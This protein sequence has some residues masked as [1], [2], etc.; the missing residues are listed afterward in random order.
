MTTSAQTAISN[1]Q[2]LK[3]AQAF[4]RQGE[5]E[6]AMEF[7]KELYQ[8][9]P[10]NA[11]Y[12]NYYARMLEN[13]KM[14][15][16]WIALLD[17]MILHTMSRP[18]LMAEKGRALYLWDH[19]QQAYD[20]WEE[21]IQLDPKN[22]NN[23]RTVAS[24]QYRVRLY[25]DAIQTYLRCREELNQPNLYANELANLY[26]YRRNFGKSTEEWL[27]WVSIDK[28]YFAMAERAINGFP[29]DS[30][31]V[32]QVTAALERIVA[33]SSNNADFRRLLS[34]YYIKNNEYEKAFESYKILDY[35]TR[36]TG[37]QIL[38][39]ANQV[40]QVGRPVFA[41]DAY[42]YFI[43]TYPNSKNLAQA[44]LGRARAY[45]R[46]G[47]EQ[48]TA[49]SDSA[50]AALRTQHRKRAIE[51]Y[52]EISKSSGN[53]SAVLE[54]FYRTGE[55]RFH[56]LFDIDGA[57]EAY[58]MARNIS[59]GSERAWEAT[60]KTGDCFL[61][62][63]DMGEAAQYYMMIRA[64]RGPAPELKTQAAYKLL[65]NDYYLGNFERLREQLEILLAS[66]PSAADL[67]NDLISLSMFLESNMTGDTE[68]VKAFAEIEFLIRQNKLHEALAALQSLSAV[69]EGH[70][71]AD[72]AL[73]LTGEIYVG[74]EQYDRAVTT[75]RLLEEL[76]PT[77]ARAE[78]AYMKIGQIYEEMLQDHI[79]AS[80]AYESFLRKF[81]NSIYLDDVRIK[82]R[83]LQQKGTYR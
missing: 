44:L 12:G 18:N 8:S 39:Y 77:S 5:Y 60:L 26:S 53:A 20:I 13:M 65:L 76:Y 6:R 51:E 50:E 70:P 73:F 41:I 31:V 45:E 42:T 48:R 4:E 2:K 66:T 28:R 35:M 54:S 24:V 78:Q 38:A 19:E 63:G 22:S 3:L 72:D 58:T 69:I 43:E 49:P 47:F 14:Y 23:Y 30:A 36:A 9:Q 16:E 83:R 46:S 21:V 74:L 82:L 40:Y 10:N 7:Y 33:D 64:S 11:V 61:A 62:K 29:P 32:A 27:N 57:I 37:N 15:E 59:P 68:Q 25:E 79:Q 75:Y 17:T 81:S 71:I 55:I 34:G 1:E 56:H 80:A 52:S 67:H